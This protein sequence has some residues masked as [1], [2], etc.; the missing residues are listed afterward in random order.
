MQQLLLSVLLPQVNLELLL[1]LSIVVH[2]VRQ[3]LTSLYLK[4]KKVS[5]VRMVIGDFY[6]VFV[7][8]LV[9]SW[10]TP[11]LMPTVHRSVLI[12]YDGIFLG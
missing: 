10:L 3:S 5:L 1:L 4:E 11:A 9:L 6:V 2:P 8:R 12:F 7:E